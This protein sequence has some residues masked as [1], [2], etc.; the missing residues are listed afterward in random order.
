MVE[1]TALEMRHACK[2]I[3]G[4]NPTLSAIGREKRLNFSAVV[5][6]FAV[7][8]QSAPRIHAARFVVADNYCEHGRQAKLFASEALTSSSDPFGMILMPFPPD[9]LGCLLYLIGIFFRSKAELVVDVDLSHF[10][11]FRCSV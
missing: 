11:L 4:S 6:G 9:F 3:V 8:P 10:E 7:T 5:F 2:G 1:C